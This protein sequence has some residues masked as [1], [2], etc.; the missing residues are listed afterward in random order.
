LIIK[1]VFPVKNLI[2][3]INA[4]LQNLILICIY[5][6][7]LVSKIKII[8]CLADVKTPAAWE[9]KVIRKFEAGSPYAHSLLK[10]NFFG[11]VVGPQECIEYK[12]VREGNTM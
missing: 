3:A 2:S 4:R 11:I 6:A 8:F 1:K 12:N 10:I 5:V 7:Y 9:G